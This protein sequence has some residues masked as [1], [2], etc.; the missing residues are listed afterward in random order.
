MHLQ[1][2]LG[3]AEGATQQLQ[4]GGFAGAV[5]ADQANGLALADFK[6]HARQGMEVLDAPVTAAQQMPQVPVRRS[7]H[8]IAFAQLLGLDGE[9]SA[10]VR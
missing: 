10:H 7:G 9:R 3:G 8:D 2:P 4:Q 5:L 1:L 6:A